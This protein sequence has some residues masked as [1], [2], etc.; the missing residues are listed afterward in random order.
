VQVD[1][2]AGGRTNDALELLQVL[3]AQ[4]GRE[5]LGAHLLHRFQI[6]LL[7]ECVYSPHVRTVEY[8][9]LWNLNGSNGCSLALMYASH[10]MSNL[11][12]STWWGAHHD[13][14]CML[15]KTHDIVIHLF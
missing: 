9:I 5:M 2:T 15:T 13:P 8:S 6:I 10:L 14:T 4:D 1:N 7:D 11:H 3:E 12:K